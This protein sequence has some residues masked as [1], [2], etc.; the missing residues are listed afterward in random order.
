MMKKTTTRALRLCVAVLVAL[1][2]LLTGCND[3]LMGA[4]PVSPSPALSSP[5]PSSATADSEQETPLPPQY[6]VKNGWLLL[7]LS[8]ESKASQASDLPVQNVLWKE[9]HS[10]FKE[11]I[12]PEDMGE[13]LMSLHL[14]PEERE[15]LLY[16]DKAGVVQM[17]DPR[18]LA[19]LYLPRSLVLSK[20]CYESSWSAGVSLIFCYESDGKYETCS[21]LEASISFKDGVGGKGQKLLDAFMEMDGKKVKLEDGTAALR[22]EGE[23]NGLKRQT[24]RYIAEQRGGT[25]YVEQV[26]YFEFETGALASVEVLAQRNAKNCI[27]VTTV[28][29]GHQFSYTVT[30]PEKEFVEN[31]FDLDPFTYF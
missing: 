6:F 29:K 7:D 11:S 16:L 15:T 26:L 5:S 9:C 21:A 19:P 25:Y 4:P 24:L 18:L 23:V 20:T 22:T 17:I 10:C 14:S 8:D 31:I 30:N 27:T 3:S 28:H 12:T 1:L 13:K 2:M